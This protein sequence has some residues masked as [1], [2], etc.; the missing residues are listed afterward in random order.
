MTAHFQGE[1]G[2]WQER[3]NAIANAALRQATEDEET[4]NRVIPVPI[5]LYTAEEEAK[6]KADLAEDPDADEVDWSYGFQVNP[7][8][9]YIVEDEPYPFP[10]P[11]YDTQEPV[12]IYL[13]QDVVDY[14]MYGGDFWEDR[15]NEVLRR[16]AFGY[17]EPPPGK[18][19]S[20]LLDKDVVDC[21]RERRGIWRHSMN[22]MANEALW[23]AAFGDGKD[24]V[25]DTA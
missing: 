6:I 15:A 25:E 13:D 11:D 14:F 9:T 16:A 7:I 18:L 12:E 24:Q 21:F 20:L 23:Q 2:P 8:E 10:I 17:E 22:V 5:Y 1:R 19:I 3:M 4:M